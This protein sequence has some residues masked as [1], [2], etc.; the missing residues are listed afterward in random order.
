MILVDTGP[1]V[2]LANS[3]D[4][5]HQVCLD[6][7]RVLTEPLLTTVPVLTEALHLLSPGSRKCERLMEFISDPTVRV[8]FLDDDSLARSLE[9]MSRYADRPMDLADATLVTC[10]ETNAISTV[11][12]LDHDDFST[13][14]IRRG[15][16]NLPFEIIP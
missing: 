15:H 4:Q 8:W 2:A 3:T 13:Y 1:L 16:K 9:L 14:R 7:L 11:F 10:A 12:T 6:A 5:H